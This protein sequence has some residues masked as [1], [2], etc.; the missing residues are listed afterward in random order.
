MVDLTRQAPDPI[1]SRRRGRRPSSATSRRSVA[2]SADRRLPRRRARDSSVRS[3]RPCRAAGQAPGSST[4]PSGRPPIRRRPWRWHRPVRGAQPGHRSRSA[5]VR[6]PPASSPTTGQPPLTDRDP[7]GLAVRGP[8]GQQA[9]GAA[10]NR[11]AFWP[12]D[13]G[14]DD[15][16]RSEPASTAPACDV[17]SDDDRSRRAR[18]RSAGP[19]CEVTRLGFGGASIGGLFRAVEDAEAVA[20]VR[21][22][23]SLGVRYFDTAPLYGYGVVG[24]ADGYGPR[25]PPARR[26]RA[27]DQGRPAGPRDVGD[28]AWRRHRPTG[29]RRPGGRL[30]RRDPQRPGSFSTTAPMASAARSRRA[31]SGSGSTG[32]TSR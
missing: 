25:R 17:E 31:S 14:L 6:G 24:A 9:H 5:I 27:V 8:T 13:R 16:I 15:T 19:A 30:L 32:S 29:P 26:R 18:R 23:W 28:P 4:S 1:G 22:A 10:P 11:S 7:D 2:P 3:R 21:H 12:M 20:T